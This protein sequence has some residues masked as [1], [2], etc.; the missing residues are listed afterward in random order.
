MLPG[1]VVSGLVELNHTHP[2]ADM[3]GCTMPSTCQQTFP[4]RGLLSCWSRNNRM[5]IALCQSNWGLLLGFPVLIQ[6]PLQFY[7]L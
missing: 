6:M 2:T 7:R 3:L 5:A 1:S 4:A